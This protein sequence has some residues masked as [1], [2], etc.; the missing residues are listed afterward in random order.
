VC[1][2]LYVGLDIKCVGMCGVVGCVLYVGD[3]MVR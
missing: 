2:G 1:L 3:F